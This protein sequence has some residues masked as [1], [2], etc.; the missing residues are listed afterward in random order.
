M[1]A[2]EYWEK[3]TRDH[4]SYEHMADRAVAERMRNIISNHMH[5]VKS[6]LE[7]YYLKYAED[8]ELTAGEAKRLIS[9][10]DLEEYKQLAEYYVQNRDKKNIAFSDKANSEMKLY[11]VTMKVNREQLILA[12]MTEHLKNLGGEIQA[13]MEDYLED[14]T[15]REFKHQAHLL[16]NIDLSDT[17]LKAIINSTHLSDKKIWSDRLWENLGAVQNEVD[18]TIKDVLLRGRHPDEG[19]KR[20]TELTGRS[21]YEARRLLITETARV[22]SEAQYISYTER[23]IKQFRFIATIDSRTTKQCRRTHLEIF[24]MSEWRIGINV[25]PLHQFCRSSTAPHIDPEK[26]V[27]DGGGVFNLFNEDDPEDVADTDDDIIGEDDGEA[28]LDEFEDIL[29]RIEQK[30]GTEYKRQKV[31]KVEKVLKKEKEKEQLHAVVPEKVS[32]KME[33]KHVDMA[34]KMLSEAPDIS[35]KVWSKYSS[36]LTLGRVNEQ[37]AH[38]DPVYKTVHMHMKQSFELEEGKAKGDTFFHEFAHNIDDKAFRDHKLG[39]RGNYSDVYYSEKHG[40]TFDDMLKKE[41]NDLVN[42][43][44]KE[45]KKTF[46]ATGKID[47]EIEA[48]QESIKSDLRWNRDKWKKE[49]TYR[50]IQA[51]MKQR[52]IMDDAVALSD[53]FSGVTKNKIRMNWGHSTAYWKSHGNFVAFE[54]FANLFGAMVANYKAYQAVRDVLPGSVEIF[55]ELLTYLVGEDE[56]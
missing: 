6:D 17:Q 39:L 29:D 9:E 55:E 35:K 18:R 41:V 3:R 54:A 4:L 51:E 25:P 14:S 37:G 50:I 11:N 27:Q 38:Y 10:V 21:S 20:L 47:T 15:V 26:V 2:W 45:L 24:D 43:R 33:Q 42:S 44:N 56:E 30:K 52:Y 48:I 40:M 34:N 19:V 16:G 7:N 12:R 36:R 13:E 31:T 32:K 23:N 1:E 49:F 28:L 46:E 8:E 53:I 22:Q 5:H